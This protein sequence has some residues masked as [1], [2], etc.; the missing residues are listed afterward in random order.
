MGGLKLAVSLSS[1]GIRDRL[2]ATGCYS[3]RSG[4]G[5]EHNQTGIVFSGHSLHVIEVTLAYQGAVANGLHTG[6]ENI[7]LATGSNLVKIV[8]DGFFTGLLTHLVKGRDCHSGKQTN[9]DDDDHDFNEC[10][11][12]LVF[13]LFHDIP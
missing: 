13:F 5:F 8:D 11:T 12:L 4:S 6:F 3:Q 1:V 7:L 10:E 9:D 2:T